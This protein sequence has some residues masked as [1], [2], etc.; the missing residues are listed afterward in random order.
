MRLLK[1]T[2]CWELRPSKCTLFATARQLDSPLVSRPILHLAAYRPTAAAP[3][4]D[5]RLGVS[6]HPG[7]EYRSLASGSNASLK[8]FTNME[9]DGL[10]VAA[11]HR[12]TGITPEVE[13]QDGKVLQS[14]RR[15]VRKLLVGVH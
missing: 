13:Q 5:E 10:L 7:H 2:G 11:R 9:P 4:S 8:G 3:S 12:R 1:G 15:I 14:T 6:A